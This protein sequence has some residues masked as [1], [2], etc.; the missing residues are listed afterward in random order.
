MKNGKARS[1]ID[2]P[3]TNSVPTGTKPVEGA[4]ALR[5]RVLAFAHLRELL[6]TPE[7]TLELPAGACAGDAWARLVREHPALESEAASLRYALNGNLATFDR[8]LSDGDEL[9]LLPPVGGG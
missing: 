6:G 9:A 8:P 3:E 7:T 2:S 5:I 1:M 4:G